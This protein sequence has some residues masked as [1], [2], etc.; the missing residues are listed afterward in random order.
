LKDNLIWLGIK[1]TKKLLKSAEGEALNETLTRLGFYV[2]PPPLPDDDSCS[3][4]DSG[5]EGHSG[6]EV[7]SGAE[8]D[9]GVEGNPGAEE[10]SSA[11]GDSAAKRDVAAEG[12]SSVKSI[13][14]TTG[15]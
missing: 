3:E 15:A 9:S 11:K 10:N 5:A 8:E 13:T 4:E 6:A 14:T 2:D 1:P 12:S 7:H